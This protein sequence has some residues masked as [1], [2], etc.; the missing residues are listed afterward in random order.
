M[1]IM[2]DKICEKLIP[3]ISLFLPLSQIVNDDNPKILKKEVNNTCILVLCPGHVQMLKQFLIK[4][5]DLKNIITVLCQYEQFYCILLRQTLNTMELGCKLLEMSS[6][7]KG[8]VN[9]CLLATQ[10]SDKKG[11]KQ[12]EQKWS[13]CRTG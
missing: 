2:K 13:C 11:Q 3:N 12:S 10:N 9:I 1:H 4:Y 8:R 5:A 6:P 7:L